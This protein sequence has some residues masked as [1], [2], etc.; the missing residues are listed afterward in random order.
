MAPISTWLASNVPFDEPPLDDDVKIPVA[1]DVF[2]G[3]NAPLASAL[4]WCGWRV[5]AVDVLLNEADDLTS[6]A[7][8]EELA[9]E[10]AGADAVC[11]AMPCK[12]FSRV[13]NKPIPDHPSPPRPLRSSTHVLGVPGLT[14][15]EQERVSRDNK[16]A[17]WCWEMTKMLDDAGALAMVENPRKSLLWKMM[18]GKE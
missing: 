17:A 8:Q 1:I 16:L 13:R 2:S 15:R 7:R 4:C 14:Q 12:T 5:S 10:I 18:S 3:K 9:A 6:E 11:F